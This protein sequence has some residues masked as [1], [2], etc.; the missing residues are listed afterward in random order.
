MEKRY[1]YG[2]FMDII[3]TLRSE[4]GCPW[5]KEQ[6][7]DSLRPCM[8][9]EAY[10]LL[11]AIRIYDKSGDADNLK[12]ELGDVLLQVA[13]HSQIAKE[14]GL[15]TMED[16]VSDIAEKMIRRHPHVFGNVYADNSDQV[17]KNWEEIKKKEKEGKSWVTTPLRD[18][19]EELPALVRASKVYKKADKL[20]KRELSVEDSVKVLQENAERLSLEKEMD[21][22]QIAGILTDM[23]ADI[24]KIAAKRS[25]SMEQT[26]SDK[27]NDFIDE[28]ER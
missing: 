1:T 22:G 27:V 12:E 20:Y 16:V 19:P 18:I 24:C 6:T 7:H 21:D 13:L 17:L 3:A 2:E 23:L 9:E 5:D 26:L 28:I 8:I 11:A 4:N 14:E 25:L 15:F 10:E